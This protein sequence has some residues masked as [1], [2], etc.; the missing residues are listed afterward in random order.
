MSKEKE[1]MKKMV[2]QMFWKQFLQFAA[3][4][5]LA[6]IAMVILG[7]AVRWKAHQVTW[8]GE[9][10]LWVIWSWIRDHLT[11]S[12]AGI[13]IVSMVFAAFFTL[14]KSYQYL[15]SVLEATES[16]YIQEEK[17]IQL[18]PELQ[19]VEGHLNQVKFQLERNIRAAKEAEQRKNDLIVYLAHDLKTPLTSVIGYL[20][21]LRDEGQISEELRTKYLSISLEKAEHLEDLINEFFEITRFNLSTLTLETSRVNV[22]RML[23]Q[24]TYEFKPMLDEK[25]LVCTLDAPKE[26]YMKF[27]VGKMQR[28]FDN[29][30]R[31]AVNYSF[32]GGEILFRVEE[33]EDEV[34]MV[35]MNHGNTIPEEKLNRIFEQ[36]FRLDSARTT[37][38][39]G[40]GLGLAIAKEIIELHGGLIRAESENEEIRFIIRMP[41]EV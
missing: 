1:Q 34:E 6:T 14:R 5:L 23:E 4:P 24:L 10:T 26:L 41:K 16:I 30:L 7:I 27:D 39:G 18:Q 12:I 38:S 19:Q 17:Q 11:L 35:C 8:Y 37:R 2:R 29:L 36:F 3:I 40:A 28:V 21:L 32:E 15:E 22:T 31:N 33:K 20:T 25:Q 13:L 9:E